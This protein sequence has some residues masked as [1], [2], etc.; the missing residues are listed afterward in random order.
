ML[1]EL[2]KIVLNIQLKIDKNIASCNEMWDDFLPENHH[3]KSCHLQAFENANIED[4]ENFYIQIIQKNK[5][6]GLL[7]LQQFQFQHKHLNFN[8]NQQILSF[9]IKVLL[10]AKIPLLVC[11]HLFRINFQGFYF[12]K[13]D[14]KSLV[15]DAVKLF[16]KQSKYCTPKGIIVKDCED[17][18]IEQKC[19]LFGYHFFNG[20]VTM[21]LQRRAHWKSFNDYLA[22]LNKKYLQRAKKILLAIE[23]IE[24]MELKLEQIINEANSINRLYLNVLSKQTVKLG[25]INANYFVELKRD[26]GNKFEFHALYKNNR[27]L[28]FYTFIFYESNK[29]ETHYIGLDYE[30]NKKHQ[31]Y[32]NILFKGV[33]KMIDGQYNNL[34]LGRTARDAKANIGA[35]PKQIFNYISVRNPLMKITLNHFLNKFNRIENMNPVSRS[36]LK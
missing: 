17:V 30:E 10:P 9:L 4:V 20:D 32:F 18:F 36:P 6:I 16:T 21:E 33:Q 25:I 31:I 34:E 12:K 22:D 23:G 7:Y 24:I 1:P 13:A 28:G 8:G 27:M 3:L 15:F 5:L 11:G 26:L 35:N 14:H 2:F 19:K 29:M